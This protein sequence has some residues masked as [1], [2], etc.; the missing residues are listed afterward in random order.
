[1]TDLLRHPTAHEVAELAGVSQSAV[2]RTFTPGASVSASTR[3]KVVT[4]AETLGYHPN[5]LARSLIT[6]RSRLV[7]IGV[8]GLENEFFTAALEALTA[9]LAGRGHRVLLFTTP[10]GGAAADIDPQVDELLRYQIDALI[11]LAATLSSDLAER[12]GRVGI[13]VVFFNRTG[14]GSAAVSSVTGQ[15]E[16]GAAAIAQ[17]FLDKGYRH[18]A[19]LAGLS[20]SSTSREREAGFM[21]AMR[22]AGVSVLPERGEFRRADAIAATRRLLGSADPP[23]AIFCA[24]DMMAFAAIEVA[25]AEFGLRVGTDVAIAGFDDVPMAAWPSFSLTTYAQPIP[26]MVEAAV[27]LALE[28]KGS[29][30]DVIPGTLIVRDSTG[31]RALA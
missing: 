17:L 2:S 20:L 23:D 26:Q 6:G 10:T 29:V 28:P 19:F 4:A 31:Q 9:R 25:R 16:A 11:L 14:R 7:G 12:C 21:N 3:A 13:P 27:T 5:V 15:N 1:M 8:G 24:N 30:H 22:R 18:P